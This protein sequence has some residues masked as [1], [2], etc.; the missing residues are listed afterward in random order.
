MRKIVSL[1]LILV[2]ACGGGNPTVPEVP[3]VLHGKWTRPVT[4]YAG[5]EMEISALNVKIVTLENTRERYA[6][7]DVAEVPD[8]QARLFTI[9]YLDASV[10]EATLSLTLIS[11]DRLYLTNQPHVTW[12][13]SK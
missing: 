12:V 1:G 3:A 9:R 11:D 13:R 2:A 8:G 10:E 5:A 4:S 6:V 7:I